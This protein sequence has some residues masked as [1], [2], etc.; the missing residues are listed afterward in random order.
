MAQKKSMRE[1]LL[2]AIKNS[3]YKE[4]ICDILEENK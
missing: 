3:N 1:K 2:L 4:T